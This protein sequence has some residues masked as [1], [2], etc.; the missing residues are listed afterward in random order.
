MLHNTEIAEDVLVEPNYGR[1]MR[2][3]FRLIIPL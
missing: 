1:D 3:W 2:G